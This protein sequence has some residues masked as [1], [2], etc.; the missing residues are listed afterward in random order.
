MVEGFFGFDDE[1]Y[2]MSLEKKDIYNGLTLDAVENFLISLGTRV[3]KYST[4]LI[5]PTICHNTLEEA[6]SMKLYYYQENKMFHCYTECGENMTIFELY[7]RY[8]ALNHYEVSDEEAEEYIKKFISGSVSFRAREAPKESILNKFQPTQDIIYC[9][10]YPIYP[11]SVFTHY[12]H[13]L[14]KRDGITDKSMD[15]FNILFSPI[16]NKIIIPHYDLR[17]KLIG[18]RGRALNEEDIELGKYRPI[19]IGETTYAHQLGFNLYGIHEHKEAIRKYR[20]AI[21]YEAE[22]SVLLDDGFYGEDSVGVAV[23]GSSLNKFQ[24]NLLVK[25]LGVNEII[26]ALDKEFDKPDSEEGKRYRVKLLKMA[27]KYKHLV[28]FY[29]IFDEQ[30]LLQKKDAPVDKGQEVFEKLYKKKIKVR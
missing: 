15:K 1:V 28:D 3:E 2:Y 22:K 26:S 7:K 14:W 27:N 19:K 16:Q 30:N 21:V 24:V 29:Y 13:P 4:Y 9:E 17:G 18:I 25:E 6:E 11:L 5:C 23:C 10:E 12:H 8:M 20:R